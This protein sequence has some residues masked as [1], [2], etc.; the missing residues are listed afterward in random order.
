MNYLLALTLLLAPTY[1]I[2]FGFSGIPLNVLFLWLAVLPIIMGASLVY[3]KKLNL[4]KTS[5]QEMSKVFKF[6]FFG[7]LI[8]SITS[9]IVSERSVA[10]I[11]QFLVLFMQPML[12]FVLGR[13]F[14]KLYPENKKNLEYSIFIFLGLSGVISFIQYFTLWSLPSDW[15]GNSAE[16]KRAIGFF[17]HPNFF[18]L[19][20]T[21]LLA[22]TFPVIHEKFEFLLDRR[23]KLDILILISWLLGG[24]GLLLSLSRGG[25]IGLAAALGV[26]VLFWG[27]RNIKR[28]AWVGV[29]IGIVLVIAIPNLRYRLI[30]PFYGEKSAVARL[31]LWQTAGNMI[32]DNPILGKG[33]QGFSRNWDM[34]NK[35]ANLEHYN[36]PHNIFLNFWVDTGLLGMISFAILLLYLIL[37]AFKKDAT[38]A[39]KQMALFALALLIHG[40]IDI[41]YLK[42]DLAVVFW[43]FISMTL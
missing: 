6:S 40:L 36:F 43:L 23:S 25:W 26:Y 34:Y 8:A 20:I 39:H 22:Y 28:L 11:G 7:F 14:I 9:L 37:R 31:S 18:S 15:W 1:V 33:T 27:S 2:R 4:I 10:S 38:T 5:F 3:Y 19:F 17:I 13:A 30:L 41:P 12:L 35:D 42:N 21:P 32:A 24:F 29:V 16:P